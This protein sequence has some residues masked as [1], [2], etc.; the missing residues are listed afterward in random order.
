LTLADF[1]A[2]LRSRDIRLSLESGRLRCNAPAGVLTPEL[3]EQLQA[4]KP[5]L[6]E[7]LRD[8]AAI[9]RHPQA[10]VPLQPRGSRIPVYGIGGHTGDFFAY[11]DLVRHLGAEQPFYGLHPPGLDER[12]RPLES[13]EALATYFAA[14]VRAFHAGG[15]CIIA[16]YC[17][18]GACALELARQLSASRTEVRFVA[19]FGC[20]HPTL[21]R[22]SPGY[23]AKRIAGHARV[24]AALPTFREQR[25]YVVARVR[26]RRQALRDER[27][28]PGE[29]LVSRLRFEFGQA[30]IAAL[31]R[32]AP[33]HYAGRVCL[34][35]PNREWYR[36]GGAALRWRRQAPR[37]EE[38]YGPDSVDPDRMLVD[39]HA[40]AFAALFNTACHNAEAAAVAPPPTRLVKSICLDSHSR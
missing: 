14:Q 12:S 7:F 9:A 5:E 31:K 32:H 13:A 38:Y 40:A 4:R 10:I 19:L 22:F 25:E 36:E 8:A 35:L 28:P 2:E 17:A 16:G 20:P 34:F 33:R 3:R 23:W 15:A 30:T 11:Q 6:V 27:T 21:Y 1:L 26:A 29:D 24:L 37:G 18:G 39:P